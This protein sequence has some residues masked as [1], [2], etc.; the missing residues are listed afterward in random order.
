MYLNHHVEIIV[1]DIKKS[2]NFY[3]NI[4]GLNLVFHETMKNESRNIDIAKLSLGDESSYS[5]IKLIEQPNAPQH[6][7]G[8]ND[9]NAISFRV[10]SNE[11]LYYY[12]E[13]LNQF[14]IV[15]YKLEK[16]NGHYVLPFRGPDHEELYLISNEQNIGLQTSI[17]ADHSDINPIHQVSGLGPIYLT[18]SD[19]ILTGSVFK[20][21][22]QMKNSADYLIQGV[23]SR[24]HVFEMGG[25]GHGAEIHIITDTKTKTAHGVGMIDHFAIQVEAHDDFIALENRINEI[26]LPYEKVNAE[27]YESIFIR[28]MNKLLIEIVDNEPRE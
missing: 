28:D 26:K 18:L 20:E 21:L 24:V 7:T 9:I 27:Q 13:R 16:R 25:K 19:P 3:Q 17:P 1:K 10:P 5:H 6:K 12:A 15:Q 11:S 23:E 14:D 4:L 2:I 8:Y 22:L